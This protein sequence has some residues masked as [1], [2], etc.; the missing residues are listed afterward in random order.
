[1]KIRLLVALPRPAISFSRPAF[2]Q[3]KDAVDLQTAQK[4]R[5]LAAKYDAASNYHDAT[6]GGAGTRAPETPNFIAATRVTFIRL[7][8]VRAIVGRPARRPGKRA[9]L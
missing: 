7:W 5:A 1:M 9:N 8:S 6:G 4:V 3:Q 2:A